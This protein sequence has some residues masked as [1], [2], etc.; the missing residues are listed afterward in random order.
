ML[1][2]SQIL[3]DCV[4]LAEEGVSLERTFELRSLPRLKDLL[5]DDGGTLQASFVFGKT[6]S[7][8]PGAWVAIN[9][10]P[11]LVCQRCLERFASPVRAG[12]EI[13]FAEETPDGG[14]ALDAGT[15]LHGG[16]NGV[17]DGGSNGER[18]LVVA[19]QGMVSLRDLAEEELLLALPFAP[20]CAT[21]SSC[22]RAPRALMAEPQVAA[23]GTL[24][25]FSAL[26]ELLKKS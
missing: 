23:E 18:E 15:A 22:G 12:S 19:R 6:G 1:G 14:P 20:A 26:K 2:G 7:G 5:A 10:E 3:V 9:A 8:R 16:S 17:S 25:P 24:R 21:P 13:E 11:H 4:R